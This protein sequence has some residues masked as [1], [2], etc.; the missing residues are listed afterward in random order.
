MTDREAAV[1]QQ[2]MVNA[3][4][5]EVARLQEANEQRNDQLRRQN[6]FLQN[7]MGRQEQI[8]Q[9]VG[10]VTE[11]LMALNVGAPGGAAAP[12]PVAGANPKYNLKLSTF[13]FE[14][15]DVLLEFDRFEQ[16]TR[17]VC[18]VQGY[19]P[20]AVFTAILACLRGR[21]A[22]IARCLVGKEREFTTLDQFFIR[23]RTLFLSPQFKEKAKSLFL[24]KIQAEK[25]SVIS[26]H[27][28][29]RTLWSKAYD[30]EER[31]ET[32]LINQFISGL[33][34]KKIREHLHL[35]PP[36]NYDQALTEAI[37]LEGT[38]DLILLEDRRIAHQGQGPLGAYV[39]KAAVGGASG[40]AEPMDVGT[41]K[42]GYKR[43]GKKMV[44]GGK[45]RPNFRPRQFRAPKRRVQYQPKRNVMNANYV[46]PRTQSG[47][48]ADITCFRCRKT[49]HYA[50]NCKQRSQSKGPKTNKFQQRKVHNVNVQQTPQG[51]PGSL[52]A[53][54][55]T[56]SQQVSVS[57]RKP[58]N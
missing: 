7:L 20:P 2:A 12:G 23:L 19:E 39:S 55:K 35:T 42:K 28:V 29:L 47:P 26:Y 22:D 36:A 41:L 24:T 56:R 8:T 5:D 48:N 21:A 30:D 3:L 58:K 1:A 45:T 37:R 44:H 6:E 49:G 4:R 53:I 40:G 52:G 31:R 43:F 54:P 10:M 27:G 50:N 9:N 17:F 11:R 33:R 34:H 51:P 16:H 13:S 18:A 46:S 15:A 32:V 57:N 38:Y 14:G 25:E